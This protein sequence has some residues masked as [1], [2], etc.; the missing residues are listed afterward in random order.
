[1]FCP[2]RSGAVD[3]VIHNRATCSCGV[4]GCRFDAGPLH[5]PHTTAT[6][7]LSFLTM[8]RCESCCTVPTPA[9]QHR[10]DLATMTD[11]GRGSLTPQGGVAEALEDQPV[12][13]EEGVAD[14]MEE[15]LLWSSSS[16][17]HSISHP[18]Q[19]GEG[20]GAMGAERVVVGQ[21]AVEEQLLPPPPEEEEEAIQASVEESRRPSP[22]TSQMGGVT[23]LVKTEWYPENSELVVPTTK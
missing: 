8:T 22:A 18:Q 17:Q 20:G 10:K 13:P 11:E 9:V 3:I 5:T 21:E 19:Q 14:K 6:N 23:A 2:E 12:H 7:K 16:D 15:Q 1:M 4:C